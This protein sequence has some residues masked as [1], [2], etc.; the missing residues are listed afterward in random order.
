MLTYEMLSAKYPEVKGYPGS[1]VQQWIDTANVA[2]NEHRAP[3]Q[4][5]RARMLYVMHQL[6]R[7]TVHKPLPPK[8]ARL[9][10]SAGR[11]NAWSTTPHGHELLAL[12]RY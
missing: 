12:T 1:E 3:K 7:F 2:I 11:Q 4:T 6:I 8:D 9:A 5:D 10:R